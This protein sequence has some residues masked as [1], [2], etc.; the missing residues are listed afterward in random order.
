M[1]YCNWYIELHFSSF[2]SAS[3]SLSLALSTS[4]SGEMKEDSCC[5][6][7]MVKRENNNHLTG[8]L[9]TIHWTFCS[10]TK[11]RLSSTLTYFLSL[12]IKYS[13]ESFT[14]TLLTC[15]LNSLVY[16]VYNNVTHMQMHLQ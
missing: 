12:R 11:E 14:L 3:S 1:R 6:F 5:R 2:T 9:M 15:R 10:E 7:T 8:E 13:L 16:T 4:G